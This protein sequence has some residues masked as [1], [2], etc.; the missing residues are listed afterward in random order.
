MFFVSGDCHPQTIEVMQTRAKPLGIEVR[1]GTVG[2]DCRSA[3]DGD[4]FG[5]LLQYPATSGTDRTTCAP[6]AEP[7][8]ASERGLRASRPTCWR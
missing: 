8:H 7:A 2:D 3:G 1:V 6:L 4:Y 5:V